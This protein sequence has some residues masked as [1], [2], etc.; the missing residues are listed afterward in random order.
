MQHSRSP[1]VSLG[2]PV[3]NGENFV[4]EAIR[5][6]LEQDFGDFE[7]VITDNASTD[8]TA[9]ICLEFERLDKRVRYVRN[10]RNLG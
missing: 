6:I 10:A 9:D 2:M 8:R 5:S 4:A 7:L 1:Q 3:Y